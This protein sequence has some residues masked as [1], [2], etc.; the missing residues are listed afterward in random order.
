MLKWNR[1]ISAA[2]MVLLVCAVTPTGTHA[3]TS[4]CD[5]IAGN[6]VQNCGFET[7]N[8]DHWTPNAAFAQVMPA[9]RFFSVNS[10][11]FAAGLGTSGSSGDLSQTISTISG[12]TYKVSFYLDVGGAT[13][14]PN[15][16]MVSLGGVL[17]EDLTDITTPGGYELFSFTALVPVTDALLDFSF[18]D[19]LGV[20]GLDDV[21]VVNVTTSEPGSLALIGLGLLMV[22]GVIRRRTIEPRKTVMT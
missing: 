18:R 4:I 7:G 22:I 16:L 19:D 20:L 3:D 5:S 21:S 2:V 14:I 8:F 9:S 17:G 13:L 1:W 15:S 12:D 10:G 6:L 11:T